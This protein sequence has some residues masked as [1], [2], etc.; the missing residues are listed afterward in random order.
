MLFGNLN[1]KKF[2]F[3][4]VYI[5]SIYV[6]LMHMYLIALKLKHLFY[7]IFELYIF[8]S[9]IITKSHTRVSGFGQWISPFRAAHLFSRL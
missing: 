9:S 3:E 2:F 8:V 5:I 6:S 7:K 1:N 4:F